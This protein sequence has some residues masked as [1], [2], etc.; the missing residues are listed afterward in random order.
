[1]KKRA[2]IIGGGVAGLSAAHLLVGA[3]CEVTLLEAKP[4]LGGRIHTITAGAQLI[5]LGAEFLHGESQPML[6][7]IQA[8]ELSTDTVSTDYKL[9]TQGRFKPVK[10]LEKMSKILH[11][12]DI[13][14]PDFSF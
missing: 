6:D 5:E 8:G 12:V 7:V 11:R 14:H 10:L 2:V 1:M 3:G 13:R 9:F 4:H